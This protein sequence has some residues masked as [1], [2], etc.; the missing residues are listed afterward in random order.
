MG[1]SVRTADVPRSRCH[2]AT[3]D[4]RWKQRLDNFERA[5]RV[6]CEPIIHSKCYPLAV[7]AAAVL[8][9]AVAARAQQF[10]GGS[11]TAGDPYL[12]GTPTHLNN[13]RNA[14]LGSSGSPKYYRQTNDIDLAGTNWTPIALSSVAYIHYDGGSNRIS[15]LTITRS[16]SNN[17]GLF[18]GLIGSIRYLSVDSGRVEGNLNVGGIVANLANGL[19][20]G[21]ES[22]VEV[23]GGSAVGG[24]VGAMNNSTVRFSSHRARD[25]VASGWLVGGLI[26]SA[27]STSTVEEC[28]SACRVL[29]G[30][31]GGLIG[32]TDAG[33]AVTRCYW[34][35][36]V[37][38]L[39]LSAGS[40]TN[41][42]LTTADMKL[43]TS[44][45]NWNFTSVWQLYT[46]K[47][48]ADDVAPPVLTPGDGLYP[49]ESVMVTVTCPTP[50]ATNHYV[51]KRSTSTPAD[52]NT[53]VASDG[54]VSVP[55]DQTLS[56][57]AWVPYMNPSPLSAATYNRAPPAD[58][59]I[60]DQPTGEYPGTNLVVVL[61]SPTTN[62]TI[63]YTTN[64]DDPTEASPSVASGG[65]V[66]VPIPCVLTAIAYRSD[67]NPSAPLHVAYTNAAPV[68]T[69][70]FSPNGGEFAGTN[71]LVTISCTTTGA[72]IRYTTNGIDPTE[73]SAGS[74]SNVVMMVSLPGTLKARAFRE[75]LNPSAIRTAVYTNAAPVATPTFSP[76][77]GTFVGSSVSV[78]LGCATPGAMI[79]YTTNGIDPTVESLGVTNGVAISVPVGSGIPLKARAYKSGLNP[80]A[81]QSALYENA[82]D[83]AMPT[84]NPDAGAIAAGNVKV[85]VSGTTA[86]AVIRYTTDGNDPTEASNSGVSGMVVTVAVPGTLKAKAWASGLNPSSIK[87]AAYTSADVVAK[88]A[89]SPD[90]GATA[91]QVTLS[92]GTSGALIHYTTNGMDP[93]SASP[94]V[95]NNASVSVT[96]PS[97][98]KAKAFKTGLFPSPVRVA[99]YGDFAGGSGTAQDPY[100]I[101]TAAHLA[102]V[103]DHLSAHFIMINDIDLGGTNWLPIDD[104]DNGFVGTFDGGGHVVS[105]LTITG[106]T[107]YIGLFGYIGESGHVANI[108]VQSGS[109]SG[110]SR[111]GGL[112][113]A[114]YG[115]ISNAFAGCSVSASGLYVGGLVGYAGPVSVHVN[116]YSTG[117][118]SSGSSYVGG[119]IGFANIGMSVLN[120]YAAGSVTAPTAKG[121][122]IGHATGAIIC[123]SAYWDT[124]T[125]GLASS[126]GGTG[127]TTAQMRQQTTFAGWDF[128]SVWRIEE[129]L[130]YPLLQVFDPASSSAPPD[131]WLTRFYGSVAAAPE[132]SVRDWPLYWEYV[133]DTDPTD[134]DSLFAVTTASSETN[135][136]SMAVNSSTGRV[137]RL[138]SRSSLSVG[139]WQP[140]GGVSEK[141]GTGAA[142]EFTLPAPGIPTFY[143]IGVRLAE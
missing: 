28:F 21:C 60:A 105:N 102:K 84:F 36:T 35:S 20:E 10:G 22:R 9:S 104:G 91:T 19:V 93:T 96:S 73:G 15:N 7:V 67:L 138:L 6:L 136:L 142:L 46:G 79:R 1:V 133:A 29:G 18:G 111:V 48:L 34:D 8:L 101:A 125:S 117:P 78:T 42:G 74:T 58:Q 87:T 33:T 140:V 118:V 110:S 83:T 39:S 131:N 2:M 141:P 49:G 81:V 50:G 88:P 130:D 72:M 44:F 12:I 38:G 47:S 57:V 107:P 30:G 63:H 82:A 95:S 86:G 124:Q 52:T 25:V 143:R 24:L 45:T 116:T 132:T 26:G 16:G 54:R 75:D 17:V 76:N 94:S 51:I 61:S 103:R 37:S 55:I 59:P 112:A 99:Y 98:L 114:N 69:P 135:T 31:V 92:C 89:F 23:H 56:V 126:A 13:I 66:N 53:V 62:A 40:T 80:S 109:V 85:T 32:S 3:T 129:G 119:L 113:G 123:T 4:I 121:G 41:A 97:T 65:S 11:G 139:D 137:Y 64:G 5:V 43:R 90:G 27:G 127:K 100:R 14:Y 108:G 115:M 128:S 134:P 77:G 120:S 70:A 68:A 106:S 122:L 71:V